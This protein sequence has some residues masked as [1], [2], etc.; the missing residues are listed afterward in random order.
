MGQKEF[1]KVI[2]YYHKL[3]VLY[4]YN[5]RKCEWISN[6]LFHNFFLGLHITFP[7]GLKLVLFSLT[8][9]LSGMHEMT[10]SVTKINCNLSNRDVRARG[11]EWPWPPL[12]SKLWK[13]APSKSKCPFAYFL[14]P[15]SSCKMKSRT[16]FVATAF[17]V[18]D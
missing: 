8:G 9:I 18:D 7:D 17:Y 13:S 6:Y 4:Q 10:L 3:S 5:Y 2:P 11:P 14:C 12:F 16:M 15:S 1:H